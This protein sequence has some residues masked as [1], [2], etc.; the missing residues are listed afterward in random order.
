M[1]IICT[2]IAESKRNRL[3]A[4]GLLARR[5]P[6]ALGGPEPGAVG[7]TAAGPLG[8][9]AHP[10]RPEPSPRGVPAEGS[11][12]RPAA[13]DSAPLEIVQG[14]TTKPQ[15]WNFHPD[16]PLRVATWLSRTLTAALP[17]GHDHR[18]RAC[19]DDRDPIGIL[20]ASGW[21]AEVGR[22]AGVVSGIGN[23]LDVQ[24]SPATPDDRRW[25][26]VHTEAGKG[27]SLITFHERYQ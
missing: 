8:S 9:G 15:I 27:S 20:A 11:T 7:P 21:G 23:S 10:A 18:Y 22:S 19:A 26:A 14:E 16:R 5:D 4:L 3:K 12:P 24:T 13:G 17:E 1:A 2:T 25:L 6:A